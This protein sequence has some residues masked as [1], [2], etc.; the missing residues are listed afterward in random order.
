MCLA[1]ARCGAGRAIRRP[2]SACS[3][4]AIRDAANKKVTGRDLNDR[5]NDYGDTI[6]RHD[7]KN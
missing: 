5:Q 6:L 3:V 7:P 4:A 1:G 2:T